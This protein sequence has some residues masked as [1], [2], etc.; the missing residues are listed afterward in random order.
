MEKVF[1]H[2][3]PQVTLGVKRQRWLREAFTTGT[4]ASGEEFVSWIERDW[5]L[6]GTAFAL[7]SSCSRSRLKCN[8]SNSRQTKAVC[9]A[10]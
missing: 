6:E 10:G 3:P 2:I 4:A 9:S 1:G 5:P 7:Q 8:K